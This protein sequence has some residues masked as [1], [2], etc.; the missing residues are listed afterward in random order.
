MTNILSARNTNLEV[1]RGIAAFAVVIGHIVDKLPEISKQ[2]NH[3]INMISNWGIE[4]VIIFFVL[5]GLVIHS[6]LEKKPRSAKRFLYERLIRIYP[7]LLISILLTVLIDF[8]IFGNDLNYKKIIANVIPVST[9]TGNISAVYWQS[10]PVIWSLSFEIFFY[11]IFAVF[12]I[13]DKKYSFLRICIWFV[14]GLVSQILY[15]I[16]V[17]KSFLSYLIEMMAF[18]PIWITGFLIWEFNKRYTVNFVTAMLSLSCLPLISRLHLTSAYYDPCKFLL[19]AIV[20]IPLFS[21]L[22]KEKQYG[23]EKTKSDLQIRFAIAI[24]YLISSSLLLFD[25]SYAFTIKVLYCT[26]PW[27]ALLFHIGILKKGFIALYLNLVRP[28]FYQTGKISYS[29][30]LLHYPILMLIYYTLSISLVLKI[31]IMLITTLIFCYILEKYIQ[32]AVNRNFL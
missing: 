7:T 32:K 14:F 3:L 1:V 23:K 12:V 16:P 11:F 17:Q 4:S 2:K 15:F 5:S 9:L 18:S 31:G 30:Y 20:S 13:R 28:L 10:N 8:Y 6:S 29:L 21:F 25:S 27:L 19:F 26:L 22:S 24:I